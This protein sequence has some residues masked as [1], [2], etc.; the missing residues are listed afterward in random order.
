MGK[1]TSLPFLLLLTLLQACSWEGTK[2]TTYEAVE[3]LR[4]QQCLNQPDDAECSTRRQRY[5]QYESERQQFR[6]GAE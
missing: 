5:D 2:R 4:V 3:S 6:D 1:L